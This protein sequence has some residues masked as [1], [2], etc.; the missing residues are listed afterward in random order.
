MIVIRKK[1]TRDGFH[2]SDEDV[3]VCECVS[4]TL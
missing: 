4:G 2:L 1:L 3:R